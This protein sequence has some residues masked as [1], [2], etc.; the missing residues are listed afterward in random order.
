MLI[1]SELSALCSSELKH[2]KDKQKPVII[3][4]CDPPIHLSAIEGQNLY[5]FC[6]T[7]NYDC[8]V[9]PPVYPSK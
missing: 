6:K 2:K 7:R 4:L 9:Q 3:S 5:H 1:Q 8:P